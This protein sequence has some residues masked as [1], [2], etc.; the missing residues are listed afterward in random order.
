MCTKGTSRKIVKAHNWNISGGSIVIP[1]VKGENWLFV[2][3]VAQELQQ[4]TVYCHV[5]CIS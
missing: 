2:H 5:Q 3:I 4:Q 1:T